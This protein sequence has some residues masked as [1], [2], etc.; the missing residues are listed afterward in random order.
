MADQETEHREFP[1]MLYQGGDAQDSDTGRPV[2]HSQTRLVNDAAEEEEARA[3]GFLP[4]GGDPAPAED[5]EPTS[6]GSEAEAD[7]NGADAGAF[8]HD[9]DGQPGG[10]PKGGNRK[11]AA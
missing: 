1:K 5:G 4:A 6:S 9:G 2:H 11:K 7:F 10:A 8:D 3:E